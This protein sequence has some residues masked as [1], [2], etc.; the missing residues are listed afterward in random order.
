M[1]SHV[2]LA[3][4]VMSVLPATKMRWFPGTATMQSLELVLQQYLR[5]LFD[6]V[7]FGLNDK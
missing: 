5:K 1:P 4:K 7:V 3:L 6:N 2:A